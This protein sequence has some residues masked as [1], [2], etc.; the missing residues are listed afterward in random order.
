MPSGEEL[1]YMMDRFA[2]LYKIQSSVSTFITIL[3]WVSVSEILLWCGAF[4]SFC[5]APARMTLIWLQIAH[6]GRG[7]FGI[8]VL[9]KLPRSHDVIKTLPLDEEKPQ[10]LQ[11]LES[12]LGF[13]I[14][15]YVSFHTQQNKLYLRIY[16]LLTVICYLADAMCFVVQYKWF[17]DSTSDHTN[18]WMMVIS[19]TMLFYD[20]FP[21][22]YV[23]HTAS[24]L[25]KYAT[26]WLWESLIGDDE[27]MTERLHLV[28]DD[29]HANRLDKSV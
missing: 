14:A 8:L 3:M 18:L 15:K 22:L 2:L 6:L 21:V 24:G 26:L 25:P 27:Q 4:L 1:Y 20:S 9:L 23:I 17:I 28:M 29:T 19:L 5:S 16:A 7:V 10:T 11:T 13:E 12:M